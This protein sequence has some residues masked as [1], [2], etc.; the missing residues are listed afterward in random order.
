M[1][2]ESKHVAIEISRR[3]ALAGLAA[4]TASPLLLGW[5]VPATAD[6][7]QT[8]AATGHR[9]YLVTPKDVTGE[10]LCDRLCGFALHTARK[11]RLGRQNCQMPTRLLVWTTPAQADILREDNDVQSIRPFTTDDIEV[12]GDAKHSAGIMA[13]QVGPGDWPKRQAAGTYRTRRQIA[14]QWKQHLAHVPAVKVELLPLETDDGAVANQA[15]I[16]AGQIQIAYFSD[17][18]PAEVLEMVRKDPQVFHIQWGGPRPF[19]MP[20]PEERGCPWCGMG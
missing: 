14:A 2:R 10:K 1:T 4:A 18:C 11:Q 3:A 12:A 20:Q 17:Q 15:M 16:A 13:V 19:L 5:P 8:S 6:N 9:L 7:S